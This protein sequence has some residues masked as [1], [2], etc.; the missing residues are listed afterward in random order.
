[1]HL[2]EVGEQIKELHIDLRLGEITHSFIT[3]LSQ[4]VAANQGST[5]LRLSV[6]DPEA[7]VRLRF[8]SKRH[9][10]GTTVDFI[11]YLDDNEIN[12]TIN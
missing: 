6:Y 5:T 3:S 1:M 7:D 11:S 8:Y 2:A 12:Y 10:I 9:R 4:A